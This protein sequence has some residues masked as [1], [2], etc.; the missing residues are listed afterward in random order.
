MPRR[1][2]TPHVIKPP[3]IP[4]G[5]P[6][7]EAPLKPPKRKYSFGD[8]TIHIEVLERLMI[9]DLLSEHHCRK[10]MVEMAVA[11]EIPYISENR[12]STLYRRLEREW[13][14]FSQIR[15]KYDWEKKTREL[16][17]V[18]KMCRTGVKDE[19]TGK[20]ITKPS[21]NQEI[22]ARAE[23]HRVLGMHARQ[24]LIVMTNTVNNTLSIDQ[25]FAN[26][27]KA[28][29]SQMLLGLPY[30]SDDGEEPETVE[31]EVVDELR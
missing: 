24:P 20:W 2:V 31:A 15:R 10:K 13:S 22:M 14:E 25:Q 8:T 19:T 4:R 21:R 9:R 29:L 5:M 6:K 30:M 16:E 28:G 12:V 11:K 1:V 7:P 23:L 27:P 17:E 3:K 26:L 18:V